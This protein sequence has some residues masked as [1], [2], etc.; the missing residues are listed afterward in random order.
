MNIRTQ[1]IRTISIAFEQKF[2]AQDI[3]QLRKYCSTAAVFENGSL[4]EKQAML[5]DQ[6]LMPGLSSP[7]MQSIK[8]LISPHDATNPVLLTYLS[9]FG[10]LEISIRK[11]NTEWK[12]IA[13]ISK[14]NEFEK[15]D[16]IIFTDLQTTVNEIMMEKIEWCNK[17]FHHTRYL[18]IKTKSEQLLIYSFKTNVQKE[19]EIEKCYSQQINGIC[20]FKW[21]SSGKQEFLFLSDK[22]GNISTYN[23]KIREGKIEELILMEDV[24][25]KLKLPAGFMTFI[26][27][28][29]HI[30][31]VCCKSH[32]LEAF[33]FDKAGKFL[34]SAVQY[35]GLNVTGLICQFHINYKLN[36]FD[37]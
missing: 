21:V 5:L 25:A 16:C 22:A 23:V 3:F 29:M 10:G 24:P 19:I 20:L 34:S 17:I 2:P 33:C 15:M 11:N 26:M 14:L 1:T 31:I 7:Y 37:F 27:T 18:L 12:Q 35:V 4:D 6:T 28:D 9:S 32:S 13:D 36:F 30:L 8:S